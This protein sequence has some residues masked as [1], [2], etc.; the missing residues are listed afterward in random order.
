MSDAPNIGLALN[1]TNRAAQRTNQL[2]I[3]LIDILPAVLPARR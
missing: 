3:F 2:F 1:T